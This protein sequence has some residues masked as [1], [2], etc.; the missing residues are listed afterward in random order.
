MVMRMTHSSYWIIPLQLVLAMLTMI[1]GVRAA[2]EVPDAAEMSPWAKIR[3]ASWAHPWQYGF[4][5]LC[6][7]G[8]LACF[9][10]Y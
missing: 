10:L 5:L 8:I 6:F 4:A 3:A 2:A 1:F 7:I 9:A